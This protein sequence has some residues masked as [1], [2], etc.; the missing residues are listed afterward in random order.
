MTVKDEEEREAGESRK[1]VKY[2]SVEGTSESR[3]GEARLQRQGEEGIETGRSRKTKRESRE[4]ERYKRE[5][6]THIGTTCF[7]PS[8][9]INSVKLLICSRCL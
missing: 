5:K 2:T 9:E 8:W 3:R 6:E 1:V 7:I 4:R